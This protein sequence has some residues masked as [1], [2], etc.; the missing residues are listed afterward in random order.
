MKT[1]ME[2]IIGQ[3]NGEYLEDGIIKIGRQEIKV[4]EESF[5]INETISSKKWYVFY[6]NEAVLLWAPD[7]DWYPYHFK[8][9]KT[10]GMTGPVDK[11]MYGV[12]DMNDV[13]P[14]KA[15]HILMDD[16]VGYLSKGPNVPELSKID[17]PKIIQPIIKRVI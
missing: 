10:W 6:T 1:L 12:Y 17:L 8:T 5:D 15:Y 9:D 13:D 3:H 14:N 7:A 16:F 11:W 2:S 4:E